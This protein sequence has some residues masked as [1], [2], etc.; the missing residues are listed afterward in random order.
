MKT[1]SF[2]SKL[3]RLRVIPSLPNHTNR[4]FIAGFIFLGI[5]VLSSCSEV[6]EQ[7]LRHDDRNDTIVVDT[8]S[9]DFDGDD[10]EETAEIM[11]LGS[12][13]GVY[14]QQIVISE[15]DNRRVVS[16]NADLIGALEEKVEFLASDDGKSIVF[17]CGDMS[18]SAA[19]GEFTFNSIFWS[20]WVTFAEE[21][22]Q[23]I[24]KVITAHSGQ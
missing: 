20:E 22:G 24:M 8:F 5:A 21:E 9:S 18:Y 11:I 23:L 13:T 6:P 2:I 19:L 16:D 12:G 1:L 10:K 4:L 14:E 17:T 3:L 7:E 15:S